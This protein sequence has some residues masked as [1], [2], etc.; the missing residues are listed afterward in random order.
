[1]SA[2][3]EEVAAVV[4]RQT[5][6]SLK[7]SQFSA[8]AA[9]LRRVESAMDG[10]AFLRE[11][12]DPVTGPA[13]LDRLVEEVTINETFFFRQRKELD[14]IEWRSMF[15]AARTGGFDTIRIWVAACASGEEAYTLAMLASEAFGPGRPPVSILGTDISSGILERAR[16]GRY[17][18]RAARTLEPRLRERYF[19][20]AGDGIVV[21][22]ELRQLVEFRRHNLV[23]DPPPTQHDRPFD[24]IACRNVLIYFD[25]E[26][27]ERVI[28][29]LERSLAAHGMLVLGAA[30][31]LCGSA[32]R[33]AR[34]DREAEPPSRDW[35][36]L[37]EPVRPLRR[38]LGREPVEEGPAGDD[39]GAEAQL[40]TALAAANAGDLEEALQ[41]TDR[42]VHEEPLDA[43]A[44]FIRGLAQLGLGD[45]RAAVVSLRRAL[46]IDPAFG[47][48]AFKLGRAQ[49]RLGDP[50]AAARAYEQALR[51]LE[52]TATR[53]RLILDQVDVGDVAGACAIR[54][55]ALRS[56]RPAAI[57]GRP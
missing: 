29:S 1:M 26:A 9:A 15:D 53:H 43:D 4:R 24:L 44:Y 30:D 18:R 57:G 39:S 34:L 17:G 27:V 8:L 2:K 11:S 14:A 55:R 56:E 25:A 20:P 54:L 3:L 6:I 5:G 52:S 19:A 16:R 47:L 21:C 13:L 40:A 33:L 49:E 32:R 10:P 35:R 48:A 36:R 38:P 50:R 42:V 45:D 7:P 46:Y 28:D 12:R 41:I 31:R 23:L 22:D 37:A 51:T